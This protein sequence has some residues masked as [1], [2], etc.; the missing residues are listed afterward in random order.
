[1]ANN[2]VQAHGGHIRSER[3]S[4]NKGLRLVF[5]L[6]QAEGAASAAERGM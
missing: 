1:M 2:I 5:T 4:G 6:G 3:L